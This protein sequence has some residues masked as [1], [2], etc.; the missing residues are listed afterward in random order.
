MTTLS[1]LSAARDYY[2][3]KEDQ[4]S[5]ETAASIL[6]GARDKIVI[7]FK[8]VQDDTADALFSE[9]LYAMEDVAAKMRVLAGR[10]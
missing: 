3:R 7:Q 10:L 8:G 6:E 5:L 4:S 9:I 1:P 2:A